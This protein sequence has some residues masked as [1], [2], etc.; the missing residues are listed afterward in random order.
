MSDTRVSFVIEHWQNKLEIKHY[1][2]ICQ[3][4]SPMQVCDNALQR[5]HEFVGISADHKNC[6]ACLYH[7]RKLQTADIIHELLHVKYP[8]WTENQVNDEMY[9]LLT[10]QKY[11]EE[12]YKN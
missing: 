4:I 12:V 6:I 7:T 10:Q 1:Q 2:V 11:G 3:R 5:G 8:A 9:R